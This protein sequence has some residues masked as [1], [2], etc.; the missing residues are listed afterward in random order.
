MVPETGEE[1][2]E[3]SQSRCLLASDMDGTVIPT[4]ADPRWQNAIASLRAA[5]ESSSGLSLAYVTGRSLS[6]ALEGIQSYQLPIPSTIVCDVGTSVYHSAGSGFES[7]E[8]Y[9]ARMAEARGGLDLRV[10]RES[11]RTTPGLVLQPEDRQS[12]SKLS[13]FLSPD[14]DHDRIRGAV[15]AELDRVG[16]S[17]QLVYSVDPIDGRGLLDLLPW[18]VA[19]DFALRYLH[20]RLGLEP[21]RVV[22]AGDSGNDLEAFLAGFQSIV[23][24]NAPSVVKEQVLAEGRERGVLDRLYF[25]SEPFAAGVLEGCRHFGVLS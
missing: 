15:G 4:D 22:Y 10:L 25:A 9:E 2:M 20:E 18:G 3:N 19:K 17:L 7:D 5:I 6:L 23:V 1:A 24:G 14:S 8:A 11:L 12:Q 21:Y 16:A 13:F